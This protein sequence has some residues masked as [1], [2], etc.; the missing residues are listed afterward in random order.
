MLPTLMDPGSSAGDV[1]GRERTLF[2]G[3]F[4][5][6]DLLDLRIVGRVL[7]HA[8]LVGVAC[9]A[10][11]ALFFAAL[12]YGQ[13]LLLEDLGGYVP[14]RAAGEQ[15]AAGEGAQSL[16][17]WILIGLPA[18]G[19][20]LAGYVMRL[21]PEARGG[22]GDAIVNAFH[23][24]AGLVRRRVV[25]V[26]MLASLLT[27]GTGGV[28]GREGPTMQIGG[29]IGSLV[30]QWLGLG[31][32]ERRIL[33]VAGVA[34]GISAVFRTPLG[35]AL[36]AIEVLYR[37]DFEAEALVPAVLASVAAY[38]VV[39]SVYGE[40]TLFGRLPSYVFTPRHLP[41][42]ALL[43]VV[44]AAAAALFVKALR[45]VQ[46]LTA[47]TKAPVWVRPAFGGLAVGILAAILISVVGIILERPGQG[48]GILGGGY[49][50]A[51]MAI[52]G[53]DW[54]PNGWFGV[55]LLLLLASI[56][57]V[58]ASLTIGSG[59]S[60]GDFAPSL[61]TG[62]LLGGAF[63]RAAQILLNDPTISPGAFALVGMGTFYGGIA[64][65][66][67][68]SLVLVCELA[69]SYDLLV[70]LMLAEGIAFVA[71]RRVALYEAQPPSKADSPVHREGLRLDALRAFRV[72]E[73]VVRER[74]LLAFRP[75]T[76][77]RAILAQL[78]ET[79]GQD[80]YPVL[81]LDGRLVGVMRSD[82]LRFLA[83]HREMDDVAVASDIMEPSVSID[84]QDDLRAAAQLMIATGLRELPVTE[85]DGRLLGLLGEADVLKKYLASAETA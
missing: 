59:G 24:Q 74:V 80:V 19:A 28:G 63:G 35:A 83:M 4:S 29:A 47:A 9:G 66:P 50:A 75:E 85:H 10:I 6:T 71:L 1:R 7:V 72:G 12:E 13:R 45:F 31:V 81:T 82:A 30:A 52:R 58:A 73:A 43:A 62:A 17:L 11:G 61:V 25:G 14:L 56:K 33:L 26:K 2:D 36:L 3:L 15:F 44:V 32:R 27:L 55:G 64:H 69:G 53:V 51:Q 65:V 77:A 21:A 70:P 22:G 38:S 41:L 40:S 54:L 8:A 67:L 5:A 34:A 39:I 18:L 68:S 37:D 84:E 23:H 20:L 42:Y 49:G 79:A 60:A 78:P 46:R 76:S 57:L 48:L 16:R